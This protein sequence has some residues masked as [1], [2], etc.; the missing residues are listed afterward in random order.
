M[1]WALFNQ[2]G[3]LFLLR[4]G[5]FLFGIVWIGVL[6]YFNFMQGAFMNEVD[7]PVKTAVN[8]KLAPK[9]LWYFRWGA[10][11]TFLTGWAIISIRASQPGGAEL[12][13]TAW[14]V[15]ILTGAI[16]GSV[17]W[18]NVWFVIWPRQK[19]VMAAANGEKIDNIPALARR[20][21]LASRTNTLLSVPLLFYMAAASHLPIA[22]AAGKAGMWLGIIA[23]IVGLIE[24]NALTGDK[25]PSK[26]P[27]EKVK[28]VIHMGLLLTVVLY[29]LQEVM[30]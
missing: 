21:F 15:N 28:G 2:E 22:V 29:V 4:W 10:M 5:H 27:I 13:A 24:I 25:G 8:Q 1:E 26:A 12:L 9:T 20:A 23:V 16:M 30:L 18:F 14:G 17:M 11:G 6:W 7:A 3:L 19:K